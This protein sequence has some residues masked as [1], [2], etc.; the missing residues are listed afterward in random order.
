[1]P[2]AGSSVLPKLD[3]EVLPKN[4]LALVVVQVRIPP[5]TKLLDSDQVA[6]E[7]MRNFDAAILGTY[8]IRSVGR[9]TNILIKPEGAEVDRE[10]GERL[11]RYA[12]VAQTRTVAVSPNFV[13]FEVRNYTDGD[14]FIPEFLQILTAVRDQLDVRFQLRFGLRYINEFTHPEG[15]T[16]EG[17]R[18]LMNRELLGFNSAEFLE[19]AVQ[20]TISELTLQRSDGIF[21]MRRGFLRGTT[22]PPLS[23]QGV[24]PN[25]PFY[26]LDMD[27]FNMTAGV[28]DAKPVAL[29]KAYNDFMYRFFRWAITPKMLNY[30][31]GS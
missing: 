30:L 31:S 28:F 9:S 29:I 2:I 20:Q 22:V 12:D 3:R 24:D 16:Y 23:D 21:L 11:F 15:A 13:S 7:F 10:G 18:D 19:G 17:W 14:E 27:Y 1:M 8:P 4:Q 25:R 5:L 6:I 26:L